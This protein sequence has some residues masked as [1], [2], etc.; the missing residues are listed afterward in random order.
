MSNITGTPATVAR[1]TASC[2]ASREGEAASATD[3]TSTALA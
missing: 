1:R 2:T 3:P